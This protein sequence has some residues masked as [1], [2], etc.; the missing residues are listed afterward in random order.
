MFGGSVNGMGRSL[1]FLQPRST[2]HRVCK[3]SGVRNVP[4]NY[5][6]YITFLSR[7]KEGNQHSQNTK[8]WLNSAT[9]PK[10]HSGCQNVKQHREDTVCPFFYCCFRS[11]VRSAPKTKLWKYSGHKQEAQLGFNSAWFVLVDLMQDRIVWR[12]VKTITCL[13]G[14]RIY[15]TKYTSQHWRLNTSFLFVFSDIGKLISWESLRL[16]HIFSVLA[17]VAKSSRMSEVRMFV[18]SVVFMQG[19][20][21][22]R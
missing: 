15:L 10:S 1:I 4:G 6:N 17:A 5:Q 21:I 13:Y 2:L 19:K 11:W 9:P 3:A 20:M 12:F 18:V 7:Y 8:A 22:K 14:C 16:Q